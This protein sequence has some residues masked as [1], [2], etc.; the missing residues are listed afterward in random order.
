M[1]IKTFQEA[2]EFLFNQIPKESKLMFPGSLGLERTRYFLKLLGEPQN[3]LKVIH[4]AG[5]SGKGST[6]YLTSLILKNLG[7]PAGR[8]GF[9]VGLH[10]SPHLLDIRERVQIN[11]ALISQE[12]FVAYFNELIPFIDQ[13]KKSSYGAPTYFEILVALAYLAFFK[14][15]VDYAVI[16]TGMGGKYDATNTVDREDKVVILSRIGLDHTQILGNTIEKI[17]LQKA[18]IIQNGNYVVSAWQEEEARRVIEKISFAKVAK[19]NYIEQGIRV[20]NVRVAPEKTVFDYEFFSIAL[21]N[22]E[23]GMIGSF[24]AENCS[25]ALTVAYL[26]STVNNFTFDSEKVRDALKHAHFTGRF[27]VF[28]IKDKTVIVDIAH[29][30]Q[31]MES[32]VQ[33]LRLVF[34]H[35]KFDFLVAFKKDKDYEEMLKLIIPIASKIFVSSFFVENQDFSHLSQDPKRVGKTLEQLKM[36][37]LPAGRQGYQLIN[38]PKEALELAL[39]STNNYIVITGSLYFIGE[40]YPELQK[41]KE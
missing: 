7:L 32:L 35:E 34:P 10:L 18:E 20:K 11:N 24:Q 30:P 33:N 9:K 8:Q 36:N 2:Q 27:E 17:A 15:K 29:N 13:V 16:E 3:K 31:K 39:S 23:L 5:T 37:N 25:L 38:N 26:L 22:I 12:K 14:E 40:I 21:P 41:L 28:K 6:A 1:E 19:L 4:I